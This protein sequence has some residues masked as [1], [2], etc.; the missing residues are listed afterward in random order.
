VKVLLR[1]TLNGW[2][3]KG[4]SNW[5][6]REQEALDLG[7]SAWAVE[8]VFQQHLENVEILLCYDDPSHNVVLPVERNPR[9]GSVDLDTA[10][11]PLPQSEQNSITP[12]N[13]KPSL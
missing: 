9:I 4:L 13:K 7:Q 12:A 2:F 8:I 10:G 3:Y 1:N 11:Q 5:T 6:P